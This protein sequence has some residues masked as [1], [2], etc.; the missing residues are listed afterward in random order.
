MLAHLTN[1]WE[2][3]SF[4][5]VNTLFRSNKFVKLLATFYLLDIF[6]VTVKLESLAIY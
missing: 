6:L 2:L 5:Y 4:L 1:P 3:N